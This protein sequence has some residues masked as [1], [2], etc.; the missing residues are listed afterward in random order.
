[1]PNIHSRRALTLDEILLTGLLGQIMGVHAMGLAG[2]D[3]PA[4]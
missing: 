3:H 2:G 4:V 1:L